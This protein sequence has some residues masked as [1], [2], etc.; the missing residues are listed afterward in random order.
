MKT[1]L[2]KYKQKDIQNALKISAEEA[3]RLKNDPTATLTMDQ[4]RLL[5]PTMPDVLIDRATVVRRKQQH[6]IVSKYRLPKSL[7]SLYVELYHPPDSTGH[8]Y[9]MVSYKTRHTY[10]LD[11]YVYVPNTELIMKDLFMRTDR[12]R[13]FAGKASEA[14]ISEHIKEQLQ[15]IFREEYHEFKDLFTKEPRSVEEIY[16]EALPPPRKDIT[17]YYKFN[18]KYTVFREESVYSE[19][20]GCRIVVTN[21]PHIQNKVFR[22]I[23]KRFSF[24]IYNDTILYYTSADLYYLGLGRIVGD[25]IVYEY[26]VD[27]SGRHPLY[28]TPHFNMDSD[29]AKGYTG[30]IK[31]FLT[32]WAKPI[33]IPYHKNR[34]GNG[35]VLIG[36][37][38]WA[39]V[40]AKKEEF[41]DQL[42]RPVTVESLKEYPDFKKF[43]Q[44]PMWTETYKYVKP[45]TETDPKT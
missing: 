12:K 11:T 7:K 30:D 6:R 37:N 18:L 28:T 26:P 38:K 40:Y 29:N 17:R 36:N 33:L 23:D 31:I 39:W 2:S 21:N 10:K 9:V 20:A 3:R 24:Y 34:E 25:E 5:S 42:T 15:H 16:G 4:L 45:S 8:N 13:F 1:L 35:V 43:K 14:Y 27:E 19:Y 44:A 32:K 41:E 22:L